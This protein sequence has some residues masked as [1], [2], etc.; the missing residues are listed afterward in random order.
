MQQIR[1]FKGLQSWIDIFIKDK[2]A[3]KL[4]II[5]KL[6]TPEDFDIQAKQPNHA[7]A[8]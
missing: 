4:K 7:K 6:V 5:A 1:D 8:R 3:G 2:K